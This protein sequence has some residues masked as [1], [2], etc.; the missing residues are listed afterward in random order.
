[1]T[2]WRKLY[3]FNSWMG[4]FSTSV[5]IFEPKFYKYTNGSG[6]LMSVAEY[7]NIRV[8]V[9]HTLLYLFVCV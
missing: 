3:D 5:S 6:Y 7:Y 9:R 1:M 2:D 4:F 8:Q